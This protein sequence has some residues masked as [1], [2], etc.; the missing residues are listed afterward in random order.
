MKKIIV[1]LAVILGIAVMPVSR[2]ES[3]AIQ[4]KVVNQQGATYY[5]GTIYKSFPFEA[6]FDFSFVPVGGPNS[7]I[8]TEATMT[9]DGNTL[10]VTYID[11][12]VQ[13]D[14][15]YY[16]I[17]G[18]FGTNDGPFIFNNEEFLAFEGS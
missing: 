16:K 11:A 15:G 2:V 5:A 8:V 6:R 3:K 7:F 14:G 18:T 9:V 13:F 4:L 10:P 1:L 12:W 17:T